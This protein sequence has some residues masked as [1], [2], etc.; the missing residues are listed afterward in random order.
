MLDGG[1]TT[2]DS[3]NQVSIEAEATFLRLV[4]LCDD[5]GRYD[6]RPRVLRAHLYPLRDEVTLDLLSGW[7][8]ELHAQGCIEFYEVDGKP[9]VFLPAWKKFQRLRDSKAKWPDPEGNVAPCASPPQPAASRGESRPEVEVEV[10]VEG[11]YVA[12]ASAATEAVNPVVKEPLRS[13]PKAQPPEWSFHVSQ[14]LINRL[15]NVPGGRIPP[16]SKARWAKDIAKLPEQVPELS[17]MTVDEVFNH[18][19]AAI[20]Y[21]L[22]PDNLGQEY[23]VV[24]RSGKS[25]LE[26]WPKLRQRQQRQSLERGRGPPATQDEADEIVEEALRISKSE[27]FISLG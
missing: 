1:I 2:S 22:G 13:K 8:H 12:A 16:G 6:G 17:A 9:Y 11:T 15:Q 24:I 20:D 21:A 7:L 3:L 4:T 18:V 26:K 14:Y 27:D 19:I 5:H 10:E 23:E 25:L